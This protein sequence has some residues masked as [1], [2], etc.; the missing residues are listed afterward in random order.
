M[1]LSDY[2]ISMYKNTTH[3]GIDKLRFSKTASLEMERAITDIF[4]QL[5]V[6]KDNGIR[7]KNLPQTRISYTLFPEC[8]AGIRRFNSKAEH[9]SDFLILYYKHSPIGEIIE[10]VPVAKRVCPECGVD[11]CMVKEDE[12]LVPW[13]KVIRFFFRQAYRPLYVVEKEYCQFHG[14]TKPIT[15]II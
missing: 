4:E 10:D 9:A 13:K 15:K 5:N 7:M 14:Y 2:Q 12:A 1:N 3:V 8:I 6:A 11:V